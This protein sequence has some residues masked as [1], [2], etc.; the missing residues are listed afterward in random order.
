MDDLCTED[1]QRVYDNKDYS[2]TVAKMSFFV[3]HLSG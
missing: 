1:G 3:I 2:V